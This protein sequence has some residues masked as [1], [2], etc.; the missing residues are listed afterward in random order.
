MIGIPVANRGRREFESVVG[1]F[2]NTLPLRTL[3]DG[4]LS[5][6]GLLKRITRSSLEG[7]RHGEL[8]FEKMVEMLNPDRQPGSSPIFQIMFSML[9]DG[10]ITPELEGL[11][12]DVIE[13]ERTTA[14]QDL[15]LSS[16]PQGEGLLLSLEYNLDLYEEEDIRGLGRHLVNLLT[17]IAEDPS[18]PINHYELLDD[19]EKDRL[20]EELAREEQTPMGPLVPSIWAATAAQYQ[21]LDAVHDPAADM[22]LTYG[23]LDALA[24]RIAH[25]LRRLG[26]G[27]ESFV[28]I[29]LPRSCAMVAAMLGCLK[30]GAAYVPFSWEDPEERLAFVAEDSGIAALISSENKLGL[31]IPILGVDANGPFVPQP[32]LDGAPQAA[33]YVIYTSGSTGRPKGAVVP[34]SSMAN[35]V[36]TMSETYQIT[37][38]DK[39]LQFAGAS[40]DVAVEEIFPTLMRGA[41]VVIAP[42]TLKAD[43]TLLTDFVDNHQISVLNLPSEY[44][45]GMGS[46]PAQLERLS[47]K[48]YG[49]WLPVPRKSWVPAWI[50]GGR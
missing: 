26:V 50:F 23:R 48:V 33:A 1:Y 38:S 9:N 43:V 3:I 35:L 19:R 2:V 11:E 42:E 31:A 7:F 32:M 20:L 10:N 12:L 27:R 34:H 28:G 37:P 22:T 36:T 5:F 14:K 46:G 25:E 15:T 29:H 18:R 45:A 47:R 8:P 40:F 16:V 39:V 24:N 49:L 17:R 13:G 44:W 6:T 4:A 21:D 30:A 41:C